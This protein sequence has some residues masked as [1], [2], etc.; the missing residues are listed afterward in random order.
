MK[1][2][3]IWKDIPGYKGIY[4]IST[5]GRIARMFKGYYHGLKGMWPHCRLL[6]LS[7][8]RKNYRDVKLHNNN[9]FRRIQFHRLMAEVFLFNPE[10]KPCVNHLNGIP[11]DNRLENLEWCTYSENELHSYHVLGKKPT[12]YWL[13][14]FGKDH[15]RSLNYKK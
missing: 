8:T 13:G 11:Y 6:R 9:E 10:N 15:I 2:K 4:V 7:K 1:Y 12:K 5:E 14:K 3:E